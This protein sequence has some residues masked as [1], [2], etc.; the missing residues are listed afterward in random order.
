MQTVFTAIN[1]LCRFGERKRTY[2]CTRM[3]TQKAFHNL[4]ARSWPAGD[5]NATLVT[6]V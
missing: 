6:S 2:S 4:P 1:I 3:H 5:K